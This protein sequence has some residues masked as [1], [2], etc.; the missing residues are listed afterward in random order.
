MRDTR[1]YG[2]HSKSNGYNLEHNFGHGKQNL[3]AILVSLNLLAFAFHTVCDH[4]EP[5][6]QL[7]RSKAGSRMQFFN[8]LAG[9]T[10]FLIFPSWDDLIQTLAGTKPPPLPP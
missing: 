5:L 2:L 3:A 7:A 10:F 1:H 9:G 8:L 6:W 4:L